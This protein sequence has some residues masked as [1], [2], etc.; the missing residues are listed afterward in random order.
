MLTNLSTFREA[1]AALA[2]R[3]PLPLGL[4]TRQISNRIPASIRAQAF[5]SARVSSAQIIEAL[6]EEVEAVQSGRVRSAEAVGRLKTFLERK[7]LPSPMPD[8]KDDRDVRKLSSAYRLRLILRTNARMAQAVGERSV[9]EIP[10]VMEFL[11]NYRYDAN[12]DRHAAFDGIVLPKT[13]PFWN[14]HY[15]P[16]DFNCECNVYDTDE[17]TNST[18]LAGRLERGGRVREIPQESASGFSFNSNPQNAFAAPDFSL[19]KS[20]SI[21]EK[22]RHAWNQR[23]M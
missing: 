18:H 15:P 8:D 11:P 6:K 17:P 19:V 1:Q 22:L 20:P 21:R 3:A 7:G 14:T 9:A 13:D 23:A 12:T 10:E 4:T 16:I 5:F 2:R